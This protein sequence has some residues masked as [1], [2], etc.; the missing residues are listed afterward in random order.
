MA[1]EKCKEFSIALENA[2]DALEHSGVKGM[3]RGMH[4]MA[5]D[6]EY[7]K[8]LLKNGEPVGGSVPIGKGEDADGVDEYGAYHL[9]ENGE[10]SY[11]LGDGD[12]Y[13]YT[14]G[15]F[16]SKTKPDVMKKWDEAIGAYVDAA[17]PEEEVYPAPGEEDKPAETTTEEP[18]EEPKKD[19]HDTAKK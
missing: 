15:Y 10:K 19:K 5:K 11:D 9:D 14:D 3:K 1:F 2:C 7:V 18:K 8:W 13:Y 17:P 4:L 16:R 6:E 12:S